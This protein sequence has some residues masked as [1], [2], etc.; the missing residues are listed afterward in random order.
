MLP[1]WARVEAKDIRAESLQSEGGV[2]SMGCLATSDPGM[3]Q[4]VAKALD[5]RHGMTRAYAAWVLGQWKVS[6]PKILKKLTVMIRGE[7]IQ[8]A[9]MGAITAFVGIGSI[10]REAGDAIADSVSKFKK[11]ESQIEAISALGLVTSPSPKVI[12]KLRT[13]SAQ[14]NQGRRLV[15]LKSLAQLKALS[16]A[17]RR[18]GGV[19][20]HD[21]SAQAGGG[22]GVAEARGTRS[23]RRR[24]R[25]RV[26]AA[27]GAFQDSSALCPAAP[28]LNSIV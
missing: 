18:R 9:R 1:V 26:F 11:E 10:P 24:A 7:S 17:E 28:G 25:R 21:D 20:H 27:C 16:E 15:A 8:E 12:Q 6:D 4:L 23:H 2:R 14:K 5:S 19:V 3:H 13:I 22:G